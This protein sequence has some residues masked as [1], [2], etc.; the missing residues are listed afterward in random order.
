MKIYRYLKLS[1]FTAFIA[2]SGLSLGFYS[3]LSNRL[4][5]TERS[6]LIAAVSDSI[7]KPAATRPDT[8]YS[9]IIAAADRYFLFKKYDQ[10]LIELEKA[11][12][13]L[14]N[15]RLLKERIVQVKSLAS[16]Q[17]R[18]DKEF[19]NAM[20]S[21][22]GYFNAKDY[23]NAKAAY[24]VALE[25]IP[26]ESNATIKLRKTMEFL[27]SQKAQNI[28]Y[29]VAVASADKLFQAKEYEKAK[30]EYEN[31]SR[32]L[33]SE[34]Y[35][36]EKI[37]EIIKIQVDAQ[38]KEEQYAASIV[39][40]DEFY[41][42]K[43]YQPALLEFKKANKIKPSEKYPQDRISE[44]TLLLTNQKAKDDAYIKA[45]ANADQQF[46]GAAYPDA[47]T[48]YQEASVIKPEQVYPKNRIREIENILARGKIAQ[49]TYAKY[50][51]LGDSLYIEKNFL[52]ARENYML[53]SSQKPGEAYPK[54][55]VAKTEKMLTGQ[56]AEMARALDEQYAALVAGA[57]KLLADKAYEQSRAEY[58]KATGI[59]PLEQYPKDKLAEIERLLG[60][61]KSRDD[62][63]KLAV[64]Q[65][66]KLLA[67]KSYNP[68]LTKY[69]E[70][71]GIKPSEKYPQEKIIEIGNILN[72]MALLKDRD[73]QY[74]SF[75]SS[76]D[77][78][79][80]EK[81]Y[82]QS[83]SEYQKA[84]ALKPA[85]FYP[86]SKI[87]EID[88]LLQS[89]AQQ[90]AAEDRY[91]A[92]IAKADSMLVQKSWEQSK[93][94]YQNAL[95]IKPA[96]SYPKEKIAEINQTLAVLA[97][98]KAIR[99]QYAAWVVKGDN[100]FQSKQ[101]AQSRASFDQALKLKPEEQYPKDKVAEIDL[102]LAD[103]ATQKALMDQYKGILTEADKLLLSKS[104]DQARAQYLNA[105]NLKPSEQY[106]KDKVTQIDRIIGDI[107]AKKALEDQYAQ[108]IANAEKLFGEKSYEMA[109]TEFLN[110]GQLKPAEIYPRNKAAEIDKI[111]AA[112]ATQKALDDDYAAA[113]SG[114]DKLLAEKSF[115]LAKNQ[116]LAALK[117]KPAEQ[118][119]K[120][121]LSE[122]ERF[123]ADISREKAVD[124]Q[125]AG[126]IVKAD[127]FFTE[128]NYIQARIE[129]ANASALKP[130]ESYP[131]EKMGEI[132]K[133]LADLAAL[134][135]L[136][137]KYQAALADAEKLLQAGSYDQ[138]RTGFVNAGNI[139]PSEQLPK[140]K[141]IGI[142]TILAG[143]AARKTLDENYKT[144]LAKADQLLAAK[145]YEQ[146]KTEYLSASGWKPAEQYPK[147]K[148]AEIDQALDQIAKQKALEAEYQTTIANADKLLMEKSF[149][150]AREEYLRASV[151]KPA[152]Q[153]P[154]NKIA[155][156]D[157]SLAE[158]A[159]L[160][161]IDDQYTAAISNA[162]KLFSDLLYE[163]AKSG[164]LDAQKI[165][166]AEQY[167]KDKL[168]EIAEILAGMA[169][170]KALDDQYKSLLSKADLLFSS[171]S[172]DQAKLEFGNALK[173]KPDEQYPKDKI[174]EID[175][176]LAELKARE[177]SYKASITKADQLLLQKKYEDAHAEYQNALTLKPEAAY[178]KEKMAEI[179]KALEELLGKR[180]VFENLLTSGDLL[181]GEKDYV[182]AKNSFQQALTLFPEEN[183]PKERLNLIASRVDSIYRANKSK[184]DKAVADGDRAFGNFEF[185][186][187]IDAFQEARTLLP[188][189]N[190]PGEMIAKIRRTIAENAIVDV[191]KTTVTI[192]AGS[193]KQFSFIPVNM[194]SRKDN[195]VYVKIRNLSEK[196][197]N[198]LM[199]YGKDKQ[200]NGGVVIRNLSMDGKVNERL[201][202][203]RD[204]D[205]WYREDN[206][207]ISL[208]PQGGDIEVSFIQVSRAK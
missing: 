191:L 80:T 132:E 126:T 14:P 24:Q 107:A 184:Y 199:R 8:I 88:R 170:K 109:R 62:Q 133:I 124:D 147:Q 43:N 38:V 129:Y 112:I 19:L 185:D 51:E 49:E 157:K 172:Y 59:K 206:N 183:Y 203:V 139:K 31:A 45:I 148:I 36:K 12:Q 108:V 163:Q 11:Q 57:D 113:I 143:I 177:D 70:A 182:R 55:M 10:C 136:D 47:L 166:P 90:K 6:S 26:G 140:D 52:K 152:E 154:R 44:L 186:K 3:L 46:N 207:W 93:N 146:A 76:G 1:I 123:L 72:E 42:V 159:R 178:P 150:A 50:I 131:K 192:T 176:I 9:S 13:I 181:L 82:D 99:D 67:A 5:E 85:E 27:R 89:A 189:E 149:E 15:D 48:A 171:K 173:V 101:Y 115:E 144:A 174:S 69:Q 201:I 125:Y 128:K 196:Q 25:I 98:E 156:A 54:E 167:P 77:K 120:D 127:N 35:S 162:D 17:K 187:A 110:A 39:R 84:L 16:E 92:L 2:I 105:G 61:Q 60:D 18:K 53:A 66:D 188:M 195:F 63:Y 122:T 202:S 41:S 130:L 194:A 23:L 200:P 151:M 87:A 205:L 102:L 22:D 135:A 20:T 56:E 142:D 169:K 198:V 100:F 79:F 155:E 96:E 33:P 197:F 158:K 71:S 106:P 117:L 30:L 179:N 83:R 116:Y 81:N 94:E 78:L 119:P 28:L 164:Y 145:I 168:T 104:Y 34:Q 103:A 190:Y 64:S 141:I 91:L 4:V 161:A 74:K 29:D 95:K 134:K 204:Q 208:Y 75:L 138:A 121:K 180:K 160:K 193:E 40:G 32:I 97:N 175:G 165:K 73:E 86:K 7:D 153:Y 111:L 137:E 114:G 21:G 68:A 58:Q 118:Y 37:N 65:A